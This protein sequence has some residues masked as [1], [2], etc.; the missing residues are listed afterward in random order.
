MWYRG[1]TQ[2]TARTSKEARR[3][4]RETVLNADLIES[5][6]RLIEI[7]KSDADALD[8]LANASHDPERSKYRSLAE[9]GRSEAR[10]EGAKL[11]TL[12][13]QDSPN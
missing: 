9:E 11:E 13:N 7:L 8:E 3:L 5:K 12:E 6:R 1:H 4:R 10:E 2:A